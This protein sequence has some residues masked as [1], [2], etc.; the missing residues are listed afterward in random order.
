MAG[1]T[2]GLVASMTLAG[3]PEMMMPRAP[4]KPVAG[5]LTSPTTACTPNSRIRRAMRWQYW[6]P[7]LRTTIWL[8][9]G[10]AL[11]RPPQLLRLLE[12]LALGLDRRRDDELRLLQL[13]DGLR[14]HRAHARADRAREVERA[15]LG[16]G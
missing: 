10:T 7:A 3:P 11:P 8:T 6:P 5:R 1:S 14:A 2:D 13:A 15:G 9:R 4:L 16:E 12:D